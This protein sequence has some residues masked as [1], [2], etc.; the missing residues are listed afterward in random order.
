MTETA[1][2]LAE[3]Y[4]TDETAWLDAMADLL[5]RGAHAD[6]DYANLL[7]FVTDMAIRDRR[8]VSSRLRVFLAH[9]L[10]WVYQPD[11]RSRSWHGTILHQRFELRGHVEGGVLRN[12]AVAVLED[13]YRDAVEQ[14]VAETGLPPETFPAE[15][16]YT[17]DEVLAF[18]PAAA[19]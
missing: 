6:L 17:L 15:C 9:V 16:P 4:A 3:L 12:H 5:R 19:E 10:K 13:V 14:A 7:E 11:H 18:D 1:P 2:P 8:E